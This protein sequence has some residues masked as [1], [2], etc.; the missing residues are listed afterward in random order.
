MFAVIQ[1]FVPAD[2]SRQAELIRRITDG[3]LPDLTA[4]KD[5]AGCQLVNGDGG[6]IVCIA[7]FGVR[8][9][10]EIGAA[11]AGAWTQRTIAPLVTEGSSIVLG[12]VVRA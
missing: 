1:R 5:A 8:A 9:S 6:E 11:L 4:G 3:L 10:A 7:F 2:Q 12:E